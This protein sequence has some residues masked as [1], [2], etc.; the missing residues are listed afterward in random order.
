[1]S[2]A[3]TQADPAVLL[4]RLHDVVAE[5]QNVSLTAGTDAEV[6]EFWQ[7]VETGRRMLETV[8]HVVIGEVETRHLPFEYGAR[9]TAVLARNLLRISQ[10]E[11][12]SRVANA[13]AAGARRTVTGEPQPPSYPLVAAAQAAGTVSRQQA[14][15]ITRTID[16][17][18]PEQQVDNGAWAEEFL[19]DQ[20]T[21][22]DPAALAKIA[23]HLGDVFD[24]DGRLDPERAERIRELRLHEKPDG[25]GRIC[26]DVTA[27]LLEHLRTA[28]ASLTK[29]QT[30]PD[31]VKDP[32][33]LGQRHH[34]G[35]LALVKAAMR[36]G[37]LPDRGGVTTTIILTTTVENWLTGKG[38]VQT[39][40]GVLIATRQ[41]WEWAGDAQI[42]AVALNELKAIVG[43]SDKHRLFTENQRLAM[44]AR[45]KGCAFPGCP[46]PAQQCEAHHVTEWRDG[47]TTRVDN[48]MLLCSFNHRNFE[49]AGWH[50]IM[51]NG[52]P[53]FIPPRWIDPQQKPIRN[54]THD[55]EREVNPPN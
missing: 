24:P 33:S 55:P 8:D 54:R 39:G 34:D 16:K 35:L 43:Y 3:V 48:G 31:G 18:P 15:L 44:T 37:Q 10:G 22:L 6:L 46:T 13:H 7:G 23:H 26:G 32:R 50:A 53:H 11:A 38:L 47:G 9:S 12:G 28:L 40:H 51:I 21:V 14:N 19:V 25:S 27:E 1:M 45:D 17:L 52:I 4:A 29:P 49:Q 41:A 5:L 30:G 36:A 2:S 42:I 20:A